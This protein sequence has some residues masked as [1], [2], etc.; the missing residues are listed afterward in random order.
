[1]VRLYFY[2]QY[3]GHDSTRKTPT[4]IRPKVPAVGTLYS[5]YVALLEIFFLNF[6]SSITQLNIYR[7]VKNSIETL[8]VCRLRLFSFASDIRANSN[9]VRSKGF[10][11]SGRD[12]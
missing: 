4:R 6:F 3:N 10:H 7:P 1:M 8:S 2:T 9:F 5:P 11:S 12:S